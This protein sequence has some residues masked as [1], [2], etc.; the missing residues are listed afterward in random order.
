M[1]RRDAHGGRYSSLQFHTPCRSLLRTSLG[2][3]LAFVCLLDEGRVLHSL[4]PSLDADGAAWA[5]LE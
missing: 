1:C 4:A 5:S 3:P 2:V